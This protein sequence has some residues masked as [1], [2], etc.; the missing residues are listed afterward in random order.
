VSR[1]LGTQRMLGIGIT[2]GLMTTATMTTLLLLHYWH[3]IAIFVPAMLLGFANAL[4]TPSSVSGA[5]GAHPEIAGAASGL[6]GFVQLAISA[7][8]TQLVANLADHTP[9]PFA[10][11]VFGLVLASLAAYI[12]IRRQA[13]T[14]EPSQEY[15]GSET[16][17]L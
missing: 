15:D 8:A 7:A 11:T 12:V 5:I 6:V 3:P 1:R 10:L 2:L 4:C 13:L 9:I 14:P 16:V 17:T